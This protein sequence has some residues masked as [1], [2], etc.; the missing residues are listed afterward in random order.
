MKNKTSKLAIFSL[1]FSALPI[2]LFLSSGLSYEIN[3]TMIVLAFILVPLLL[4][5]ALVTSI[6]SLK[7]IKKKNLPGEELVW[8]SFVFIGLALIWLLFLIFA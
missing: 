4:V 6:L 1:I 7:E 5:T 8:I 2:I 3:G